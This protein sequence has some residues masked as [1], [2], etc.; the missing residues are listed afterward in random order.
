MRDGPID[1]SYVNLPGRLCR[2]SARPLIPLSYCPII[3]AARCPPPHVGRCRQVWVP[4]PYIHSTRAQA[5]VRSVHNT[6]RSA[7]SQSAVNHRPL[8]VHFGRMGDMVVVLTLIQALRQRFGT[9]VDVVCSGYWAKP[10]LERQPDVGTVYRI[11]SPKDAY[12]VAPNQWRV[13]S[14]LHRRRPGPTWI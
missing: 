5:I 13:V 14:E 10:M 3:R 2:H 9:P 7:A 8:V 4:G 11:R 6:Y 1:E 12:W